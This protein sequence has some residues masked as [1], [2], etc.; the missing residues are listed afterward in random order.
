[1]SGIGVG[2][3]IIFE[4]VGVPP[5]AQ[6]ER[7]WRAAEAHTIGS[8]FTGWPWI[9]T[10]LRTMPP[11]LA[12]QLIRARNGSGVVGLALVCLRESRRRGFIR[13][14]QLHLNSTGDP[15]LDCITIEHNGFIGAEDVLPHFIAWFANS[16][17]GD[18]LFIPGWSGALPETGWLL[19]NTTEIRAYA[20]APLAAVAEAGILSCLSANARYQLRRSFR[21]Y[22]KY[23]ELRIDAAATIEHAL[24]YF[25]QMKALH[26]RSWQRRGRDHA[27]ARPYFERFHR[28]LLSA[29]RI[30]EAVH[31]LRVS[32]G[33]RVLGY[34]YNF[35]HGSIVYAYQSGFAD[36]DSKERPGY[37]SHALAIEY[38]ARRGCVRYDFLAGDNRLKRSFGEC[39]PMWWLNYIR[40]SPVLRAEAALRSI[41]R[42][43]SRR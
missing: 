3:D 25:E 42:K 18:E 15:Q 29:A 30:G 39:Y 31:M 27:F 17:L 22:S 35:Q 33:D 43:I 7:E 26:C 23:G 40:P 10:W 24:Y 13:T 32:A 14:R 16:R 8:F 4:M 9:A 34:L 41:H 1:M 37:V 38:F 12:P 19:G 28:E 21:S 11:D 20:L 5:I 6:L 36:D 2:S